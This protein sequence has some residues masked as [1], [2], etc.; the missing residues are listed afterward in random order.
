M[1]K[2]G[3]RLIVSLQAVLQTIIQQQ[4]INDRE[5]VP[6]A[7]SECHLQAQTHGKQSIQTGDLA[8]A[9]SWQSTIQISV[10]IPSVKVQTWTESG[11]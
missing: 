9:P 10:R 6:P 11:A 4:H 3:V 2:V 8:S 5:N 7:M 1:V